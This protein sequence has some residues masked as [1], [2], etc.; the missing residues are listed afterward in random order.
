MMGA[1][2]RVWA[3]QCG[4]EIIRRSRV[5]RGMESSIRVFSSRALIMPKDALTGVRGP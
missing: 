2:V 3:L 1:E 5:L 4:R